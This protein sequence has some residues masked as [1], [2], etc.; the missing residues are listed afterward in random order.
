[1]DDDSDDE[2]IVIGE[3]VQPVPANNEIRVI[4]VAEKILLTNTSY[5]NDCYPLSLKNLC[6]IT[7]KNCLIDYNERSIEALDM[8]PIATK[9][10]LLFEENITEIIKSTK[11][12]ESI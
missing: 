11:N 4:N 10:F 8:L 2:M 3:I 12:Y 9:K 6:R 7:I 1:M 5:Y